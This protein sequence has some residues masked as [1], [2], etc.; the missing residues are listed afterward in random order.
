MKKLIFLFILAMFSINIFAGTSSIGNK[1]QMCL[2]AY[3]A[4]KIHYGDVDFYYQNEFIGNISIYGA[5]FD[6][7]SIHDMGYFKNQ[8]DFEKKKPFLR[9][10]NLGRQ[11]EVKELTYTAC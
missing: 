10:M 7:I 9:V 11:L 8:Q 4:N 1:P 5:W 2:T 3:L 6:V